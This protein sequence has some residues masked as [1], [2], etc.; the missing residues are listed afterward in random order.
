MV[1]VIIHVIKGYYY[2]DKFMTALSNT[3]AVI[4]PKLTCYLIINKLRNRIISSCSTGI[5]PIEKNK[6][7]CSTNELNEY[8]DESFLE[9]TVV[10]I[11]LNLPWE[12]DERG[13]L[14]D[15]VFAII[16]LY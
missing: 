15:K 2:I 13:E 10:N 3:T 6:Y 16:D 4:I 12:S 9:E 1:K 8:I 14:R 7:G 5:F 11:L